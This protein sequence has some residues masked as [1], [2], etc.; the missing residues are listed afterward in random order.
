MCLCLHECMREILCGEKEDL[1]VWVSVTAHVCISACLCCDLLYKLP[2][3]SDFPSPWSYSPHSRK[4]CFLSESECSLT[5]LCAAHKLKLT[6]ISAHISLSEI[7][8][9]SLPVS[10][11]SAVIQP[12][13]FTVAARPLQRGNKG[14]QTMRLVRFIETGFL[15]IQ[16]KQ[17]SEDTMII[18][19]SCECVQCTDV[20][21]FQ[22]KETWCVDKSNILHLSLR[23]PYRKC[24][25]LKNIS[26]PA[27]PYTF[28][29]W[30]VTTLRPS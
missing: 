24:Y 14:G 2:R 23:Y 18:A 26:L 21:L 25:T 30:L 28:I 11:S 27:V 4:A 15:Y 6:A 8:L 9:F 22:D 29:F 5:V 3:S 1:C 17:H 7:S 16:E 10:V 12:E 20:H 13:C 19:T